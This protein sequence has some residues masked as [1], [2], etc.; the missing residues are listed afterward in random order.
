MAPPPFFTQ[1]KQASRLLMN[2]ATCEPCEPGMLQAHLHQA[3]E[4]AC[5]EHLCSGGRLALAGI[6]APRLGEVIQGVAVAAEGNRVDKASCQQRECH[7]LEESSELRKHG[8]GESDSL[9]C[10]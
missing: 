1:R 4:A 5:S 7:A 10:F 9:L 3:R 2:P 6:A 8:E